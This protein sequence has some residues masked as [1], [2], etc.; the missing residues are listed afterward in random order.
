VTDTPI[1]CEQAYIV[2]FIIGD[3][4][5]SKTNHLIRMYD[6]N[7]QFAENFLLPIFHTAFGVTPTLWYDKH[8]NGF[9]VYINS[10]PIWQQLKKIGIPTGAKA[11]TARIPSK[12]QKGSAEVQQ[13]YLAAFFDAEGSLGNIVDPK[14]HPRGYI[15]FQLKTANPKLIDETATLLKSST[16]FQPR[17][18][19]YDYGSILRING[20]TQVTRIL[21]LLSVKHPRFL[22]FL[23]DEKSIEEKIGVAWMKQY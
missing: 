7:E 16:G 3:G 11:R 18:Y 22:P 5:L 14:R 2:G 10:K 21:R 19:H 15:Y 4:N 13:S 12:I 8:T 20:P 17:T 9:V 1:T 6:S 23:V